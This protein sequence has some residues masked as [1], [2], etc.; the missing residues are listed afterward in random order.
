MVC[1]VGYTEVESGG[2]VYGRPAEN[3]NFTMGEVSGREDE[4]YRW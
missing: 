1:P 2:A 4:L 3:A